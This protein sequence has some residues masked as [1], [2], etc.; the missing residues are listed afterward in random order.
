MILT[1]VLT[2]MVFV[3]AYIQYTKQ[4]IEFLPKKIN[5]WVLQGGGGVFNFKQRAC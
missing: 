3:V 5:D 2:I 1:I 4:G